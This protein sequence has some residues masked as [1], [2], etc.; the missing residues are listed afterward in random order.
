MYANVNEKEN[1]QGTAMYDDLSYL[2]ALEDALSSGKLEKDF[3]FAPPAKKEQILE[4]LQLVLDVADLADE[5]ATRIIFKDTQ[6]E[7]LAGVK[8]QSQRDPEGDEGET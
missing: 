4:L 2:K 8:A 1:R 5:T 3:K 6:L 7:M